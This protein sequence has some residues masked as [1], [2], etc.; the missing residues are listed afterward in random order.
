MTQNI[1]SKLEDYFKEE[2]IS[3]E[4]IF[5]QV[6]FYIYYIFSTRTQSDLYILAKLLPPK[7]LKKVIEYF[8]GDKINVPSNDELLEANI[9]AICY[10]LKEVREWNWDQIKKF[11]P[12]KEYQNFDFNSISFGKK[13][14]N[15]KELLKKDLKDSLKSLDTLSKK[16]L[17]KLLRQLKKDE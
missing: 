12:S 6:T 16:E 7:E 17:K 5:N 1:L 10:Y 9:L 2:N 15:I 11:F 4:K 8:G 13:I 14:N 3:Y